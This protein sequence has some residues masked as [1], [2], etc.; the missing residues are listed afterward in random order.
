M[1][2]GGLHEGSLLAEGRGGGRSPAA[3]QAIHASGGSLR[4]LSRGF[5]VGYNLTLESTGLLARLS[6]ANQASAL[7]KS[8]N[9]QPPPP[10]ALQVAQGPVRPASAGHHRSCTHPDPSGR[11]ETWLCAGGCLRGTDQERTL[12]VMIPSGQD[13]Q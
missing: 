1:E 2:E 6:Q 8:P 13:T 3:Q 10:S 7:D 5:S 12:P 11:Q 9:P 4:A